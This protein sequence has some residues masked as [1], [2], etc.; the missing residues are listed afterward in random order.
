[1]FSASL[2]ER[3]RL[4]IHPLSLRCF[5]VPEFGTEARN[6]KREELPRNKCGEAG[7]GGSGESSFQNQ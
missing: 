4:V 2:A 6:A 1:M 7:T 5:R 3:T